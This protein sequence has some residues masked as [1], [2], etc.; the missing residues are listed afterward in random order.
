MPLETVLDHPEPAPPVH[1]E[2]RTAPFRILV[3]DDQPEVLEAVR[4]LMSGRNCIVAQA[5]TPEEALDLAT[6][7]TFDTALIDLNYE[8]GRTGGERG[9]DLIGALLDEAPTL[10]IIVMTAWGSRDVA[11][12]ALRRGAK[13]LVEKPWDEEGLASLVRAHAELGRALRRIQEL[14]TGSSEAP[15]AGAEMDIP[16]L[17]TMR[18]HDVEGLLVRHAMTRHQGNVSRAA[19]TLGLSR[20]ALYRRLERHRIL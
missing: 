11:H 6:S 9:L 8:Q 2:T 15:A 20:S 3:A 10:P 13:D 14:E 19:R 5:T 17:Q 16:Q 7:E 18:L 12:E 4:L 1:R